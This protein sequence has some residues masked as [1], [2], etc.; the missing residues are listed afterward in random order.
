[1]GACASKT[2]KNKEKYLKND[3]ID[4]GNNNDNTNNTKK[5]SIIGQAQQGQ[6]PSANIDQFA[7]VPFIDSEEKLTTATSPSATSPS[8]TEQAMPLNHDKDNDE[9]T[10]VKTNFETNASYS[11]TETIEK[12]KQEVYTFLRE[13]IFP[14]NEEKQKLI[15]YI[16]KRITGRSTESTTVDEQLKECFDDIE[17]NKHPDSDQNNNIKSRLMNVITVYVAS[18]SSDNSF[19]KA[20]YD[21]LGSSLDL[22]S[23]NA[24]TNEHE[25]VNVTVTK[26]VRQVFV[27]ASSTLTPNSNPNSTRT[28]SEN[29]INLSNNEHN[30]PTDLPDDIR[31]KA[32]QVLN[33]FN[34]VT[35]AK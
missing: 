18:Q 16:S 13:K 27:D 28:T 10:T 11:N 35:H 4:T 29:V 8:L 22:N 15:D 6:S 17:Q 25:T 24:E 19:L 26:T 7:N 23:L 9:R 33:S 20:L 1:M 5:D 12:L 3:V 14:I 34:D 32:E 2:K 31:R 21:K 30:I